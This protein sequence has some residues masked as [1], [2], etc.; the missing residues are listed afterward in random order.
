VSLAKKR[1]R[2]PKDG[3]R[4][5]D[6]ERQAEKRKRTVRHLWADQINEVVARLSR[7]GADRFLESRILPH[8]FLAALDEQVALCNDVW[9]LISGEPEITAAWQW[10][11]VQAVLADAERVYR[12]PY[13]PS[14]SPDHD[15][16]WPNP[17]AEWAPR[18]WFGP[19][20]SGPP[21][22]ISI[23]RALNQARAKTRAQLAAEVASGEWRESGGWWRDTSARPIA[24]RNHPKPLGF[25]SVRRDG[26]TQRLIWKDAKWEP[27]ED[28][29]PPHSVLART[30]KPPEKPEPSFIL[31]EPR[32]PRYWKRVK[33]RAI[34]RGIAA[35]APS[36]SFIRDDLDRLATSAAIEAA[37]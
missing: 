24:E 2:P 37:A 31:T 5:S 35:H 29:N 19:C 25:W 28:E 20:P 30:R 15:A 26:I 6:A 34:I 32:S 16:P 11:A 23:A 10:R 9:F 36:P 1:G 33:G 14:K 12:R 7:E 13:K 22:Q 4:M 27:C 8:R 18:R 17:P 21:L 3:V